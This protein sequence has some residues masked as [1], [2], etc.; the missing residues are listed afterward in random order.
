MTKK[1]RCKRGL[2][3]QMCILRKSKPVQRWLIRN[4][5]IRPITV[6]NYAAIR[7]QKLMRR[8][9][10]KC[11]MLRSSWPEIVIKRK[12]VSKRNNGHKLLDRYLDYMDAKK[13]AKSK[14]SWLSAGF[15]SFCAVKIQSKWRMY[16]P[17]RLFNFRTHL[18][19]QVAAIVIQM[20]YKSYRHRMSISL[21]LSRSSV[22]GERQLAVDRIQQCWRAFCN[23]RIYRYFRDL[24]ITKL[25]CATIELLK[26]VIPN[27]H[28]AFDRA[29][30][31][32]ARFRLGGRIFP[33]KIYYKIYT[34]RPLCDVNAFAPRNYIEEKDY[35]AVRAN[36]KQSYWEAKQAHNAT[37]TGA[38]SIRVGSHYF[39]VAVVTSNPKGTA[40]WY[41]RVE[42]NGWR[43]IVTIHLRHVSK[44]P[45]WMVDFDA[46]KSTAF[47]YN[48]QQ[49]K[50][51]IANKKKRIRFKW[52]MAAKQRQDEEKA[53]SVEEQQEEIQK[54]YTFFE[55]DSKDLLEWR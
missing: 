21:P 11:R 9:L 46:A 47:H 24:I 3:K 14:P 48:S 52:F 35:D 36:N 17:R 53:T 31:T 51:I 40:D 20:N 34:H 16:N 33:P 26:S 28:C 7:L 4:P 27:E 30:G 22:Y 6:F 54:D 38:P 43:P 39:D 45:K 44:L 2:P 8:F 23:R 12:S 18:V 25:Q 19:N 1:S 10:V 32:H 13:N 15:S 41:R 29:N 50:V 55:A 5:W 37:K 42:N 49:R